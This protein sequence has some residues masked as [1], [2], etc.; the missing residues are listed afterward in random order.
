MN[1]TPVVH[2][3]VVEDPIKQIQIPPN[4]RPGDSFIHHDPVSG[5]F[6]VIVPPNAVPGGFINV[7]V[8]HSIEVVE[9]DAGCGPSVT[10][11][12][13]TMGATV[14]AGVVGMLVFG[15]IGCVVLAGGAAYVATAKKDTPMGQG[16]RK[17]GDSAV[18][19]AVKAQKWISKQLKKPRGG[20]SPTPA[21]ATGT[22]AK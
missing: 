13:S 10:I 2:A 15:P 22:P 16:V 7:V 11:D 12:R 5:P 8:P 21:V 1:S 19:G 6:T 3:T 20:T 4:L 14:A 18:K 9:G 17:A